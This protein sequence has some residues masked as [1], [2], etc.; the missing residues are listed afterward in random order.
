MTPY[1]AFVVSIGVYASP[2]L[3][4]VDSPQQQHPLYFSLRGIRD[5]SCTHA[6]VLAL[7]FDM[8][9]PEFKALADFSDDALCL[10]ELESLTLLASN[11]TAGKLT[12]V[13]SAGGE[14]TLQEFLNRVSEPQKPLRAEDV[15]AHCLK[16]QVY[17]NSG[18]IVSA[19]HYTGDNVEG[20]VIKCKLSADALKPRGGANPASIPRC[21]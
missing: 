2:H 9:L 3:R 10:F 7:E 13:G 4:F 1:P 18:P 15:R 8:N 21:S 11:A 20:I 14:C 12:P 19:K 16:G 17:T 6:L 5:L